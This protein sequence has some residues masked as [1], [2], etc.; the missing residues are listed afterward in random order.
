M[1]TASVSRR[2]LLAAGTMFAAWTIAGRAVVAQQVDTDDFKDMKPG[3]YTWNPDR[4]P[5]GP[6]AIIVSIPDQRVFVYRNGIRIAVSTCSTGKPGHDTPTGV[7]TILQKDK[8]HHS[9]EYNDAPMPNMNR[10][11]W[12]GVALHAGELPGYP[13]SHGCVRLPL[14]FSALLFTVTQVGTVVI[15]ANAAADPQDV[16]HPGLILSQDADNDID[17]AAE[18]LKDAHANSPDDPNAV[19]VSILV[20]SADKTITVLQNGNTIASGPATIT[21]PDQPLGNHVFIL[22]KV[23]NGSMKW[24]AIAHG[25]TAAVDSSV[26]DRIRAEPNVVDAIKKSFHVGLVFVTTDLPNTPD[27]TTG[28]DFVVMSQEDPMQ[29]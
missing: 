21:P 12:S 10:L 1:K 17:A 7:F 27:T 28:K 2:S 20:S 22:E 13:A 9:D 5:D 15:I 25:E 24:C 19:S 11:T 8:D 3:Q 23:A 29:Q 16:D 4:S 6:V 14:E 26:I 18:K